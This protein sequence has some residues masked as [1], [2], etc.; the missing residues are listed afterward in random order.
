MTHPYALGEPR[1]FWGRAM[2]SVAPGQVDPVTP[3]LHIAAQERVATLGSCFAQHIARHLQRSGCTYHVTEAA[4]AGMATAD[5]QARQYGLFSARYGNVYTI[6][7]ALQLFDRAYGHFEPLATAWPRGARWV[8]PFRPQVEPEGFASEAEVLGARDAHLAQVRALFETSE[9]LVFTLGLTEAWVDR[10][11]GAVFPLAPGVA[12]GNFDPGEHG[13]VNFDIDAVRQD[14]STLVGKVQAV[15]P[16]CRW[17][18]T[19]SPVP[20][21]ATAEPRHVWVSTTVSK[22]VLRVAADEA[23]RR[24]AHVHYFPSYEVITSPAAGGR[25]YADDLRQVTETGVQHVM[26]LFSRHCLAPPGAAASAPGPDLS[27][28]L[29]GAA[30]VVCDEETIARA[31]QVVGPGGAR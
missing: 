4:P 11:D 14:L 26:R 8:D 3:G 27:L 6:R 17:V 21:I 13:F 30:D 18:L 12:G 2:S 31:M 16:G 22:A 1:Q 5:A 29:Q 28:H 19:V 25:Y 20:L 15:N 24:F 7:Q 10:R 9:W 23:E